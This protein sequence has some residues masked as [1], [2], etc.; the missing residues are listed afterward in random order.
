MKNKDRALSIN[1]LYGQTCRNDAQPIYVTTSSFRHLSFK[2]IGR[3]S[4]HALKIAAYIY[5]DSEGTFF[6]KLE[7]SR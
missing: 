5:V 4:I 2:N 1:T 7:F 3:S 6:I